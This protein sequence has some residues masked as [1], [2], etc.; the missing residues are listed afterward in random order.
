MTIIA[1]TKR[2][3]R[4]L[5]AHYDQHQI[6]LG[7]QAWKTLDCLPWDA[8]VNRCWSSVSLKIK[9]PPLVLND[10]QLEFVWQQ[11][12]ADDIHKHYGD[13]EPLWN[14]YLCAKS[15]ILSLKLVR[16]WRISSNQLRTSYHLDHR[17]FHR[18]LTAFEQHCVA[19]NHIDRFQLGNMIGENI[20]FV[21]SASVQLTGFDR[22]TAQQQFVVDQLVNHGHTAEII[23]TDSPEVA[24]PSYRSFTDE[25][26]QWRAAG[27][28]AR[29]K[30]ESESDCRIAIVAPDIAKSR[31]NIE[32]GM[33]EALCPQNIL[34]PT[35]IAD[36]PFHISLGKPLSDY[37][38][39]RSMQ[40]ITKIAAHSQFDHDLLDQFLLSPFIAGAEQERFLRATLV[41]KLHERLPHTFSFKKF[42]NEANWLVT[43]QPECSCTALSAM[44]QELEGFRNDIPAKATFHEWSL[45]ITKL[46]ELFKWPH[47]HALSSS[48]FQT[49]TAVKEQCSRLGEFDTLHP[50]VPFSEAVKWLNR[51]LQQQLFQVEATDAPVQVLGVLETAGLQFDYLWFGSL[52]ETAWPGKHRPSPFIPITLQQKAGIH[53]ASSESWMTLSSN[54]QQR[55][56][57]AGKEVVL[58]DYAFEEEV[59]VSR[60]PLISAVQTGEAKLTDTPQRWQ[61][62][63]KNRPAL[64]QIKDN[65]GPSLDADT[66]TT[67]GTNL[68]ASQ[69]Q[70]PLSAFLRYR[71]KATDSKPLEEGPDAADRGMM[72]HH[73]LE[74]AW[75]E[76]KDSDRL[77]Q[78]NNQQLNALLLQLAEVTNLRFAPKGGM[79][80]G[81]LDYQQQWLT[82]TVMQW[83]DLERARANPFEVIK[84]E[85]STELN[86]GGIHLRFKIDRIDQFED[87]TLALIDYKTG[88]GNS[89][90]D[91][92]AP[93]PIAPQLPL[94]ALAQ[95]DQIKVIAYG[96]VRMGACQF[97][98]ISDDHQFSTSHRDIKVV[99]I[100][101]HRTIGKI[102][103]DWES[104]FDFWV[105]SLNETAKEFVDGRADI[106]PEGNGI[107]RY[108]T[109]PAFCRSGNQIIEPLD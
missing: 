68:V 50:Q 105:D 109:T 107:C 100:T 11:I 85:E 10:G 75:K 27:Y 36:R 94:Y 62:Y 81:F 87:G 39:T 98:G 2:L 13:S 99:D 69:A 70:C 63:Q 40:T 22:L 71:L 43:H 93:R 86:L 95:A 33:I 3:S 49:M 83:F 103:P 54:Q 18:W 92:I 21:A 60:S 30:L 72:I 90:T 15:A 104:L 55:L 52:I 65:K 96:Q 7:H 47:Y 8:W 35:D 44:L 9:K 59:A 108:C 4:E 76:I 58:S 24:T 102:F 89:L 91:W 80:D 38:V 12:I 51:R 32:S 19:N 20:N 46:L 73:L 78:Y 45:K 41:T 31:D 106:D 82:K 79:G 14:T 42:F 1:A 37:P 34:E 61:W 74:Q 25:A 48:E 67:G 5:V 16:S 66:Q 97:I 53:E 29:E 101:K 57:R 56:L 26:E 6:A 77:H 88:S 17:C 28:W 84:V 23:E 64:T